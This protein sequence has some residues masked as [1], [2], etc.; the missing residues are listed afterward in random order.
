MHSMFHY[1]RRK[2]ELNYIGSTLLIFLILIAITVTEYIFAIEN[3]SNGIVLSLLLTLTI[4][5]IIS[6]TEMEKDFVK[7]AE[8]LALLP[9][10]VLFTSSLPW[11]FINQQYLLPAVYSII[12]ALCFWHIYEHDVDMAD[13]GLRSPHAVK[14]AIAGALM[15]V[16]TGITEYLI[17]TPAPA[18]PSFGLDHLLLD[19]VYR[20]FFVGLAEELLF[21]GII[22]N[23]L[24]RV[25]DWKI[26][27]LAQGAMFGIMHLTWR[28][29]YEVLF[30]FL[31]GVLLGYFYYRTKSLIGP[32]VMHGVNN[33]I[34]VSVM[35][36]LYPAMLEWLK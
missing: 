11:F 31:A 8:S 26:G 4:Y 23:D 21:R 27:L 2:L 30:T 10:Y 9:L 14:Y 3:V 35:P 18:F 13:F 19:A 17:L 1:I 32:I 33:I 15:A 34:L 22:F 29:S 28:S 25:F 6:V 20:I 24:R 12:L 16:P 7:S 5:I 36:Y